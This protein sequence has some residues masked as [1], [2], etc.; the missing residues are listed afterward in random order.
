VTGE[1]IA[2]ELFADWASLARLQPEWN[3]LLGCS[4]SDTLF[5]TWEWISAWAEV[6]GDAVQP[7]VLA[8]RSPDGHLLG[9]APFYLSWT[10]LFGG[11]PL[12]ALRILGDHHSGAE[13][14]DWILER[15]R[16]G[17]AARALAQALAATRGKWDCLW[18]PN[19]SGWMGARDRI[20]PACVEFGLVARERSIEFSSVSLPPR[21]EDYWNRLSGNRRSVVRRQARKAAA[22]G[23]SLETC[24][25]TDVL[26]EWVEALAALNHSR[27][28]TMGQTGTFRRK[29]FEL[30][31][32]HRFTAIALARG[33]LRMFGL[34]VGGVQ[35]AIQI[36]YVYKSSVLQLQEGFDPKASPGIGNVLRAQVIEACIGE[37]VT[38]YDFLGEHND[39][40]RRWLAE[41]RP[42]SDL[43]ITHG[44]WRSTLLRTLGVW[45]TG[46]YLRPQG[47]A[48]ARAPA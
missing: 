12:R 18:M 21:Y 28:R 33:W 19:T 40:K 43:L 20:V 42:G 3:L 47:M 35:K 8:A 15:G 39:H 45:P 14:G 5:L 37:G 17:E 10:W 24:T 4:R 7:F 26:G 9:L 31:F 2:V 44:G 27:W 16:E 1:A 48:P 6:V 30:A 36:G 46:R 11:L 22:V 23:A 34:K 41:M 13:Y 32:Y 38:T 25:T 29:P